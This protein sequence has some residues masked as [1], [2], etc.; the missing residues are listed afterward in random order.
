MR[1]V[2]L[3]SFVALVVLAARMPLAI[4]PIINEFVTNSLKYAF[5]TGSRLLR[6]AP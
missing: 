3:A 4:G 5:Q 2:L 6:F 1:A